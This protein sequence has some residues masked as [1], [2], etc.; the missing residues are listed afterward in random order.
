MNR[1]E[2]II[3]SLLFITTFVGSAF[4]APAIQ[5]I[6]ITNDPLNVRIVGDTS[7]LQTTSVDIEVLAISPGQ[8]ASGGYAN[9]VNVCNFCPDTPKLTA[10]FAFAPT[11]G[12]VEV[13]SVLL[14]LI[15]SALRSE[16]PRDFSIRLNGNSPTLAPI[17]FPYYYASV[18]PLSPQ[19]LRV[20]ANFIDISATGNQV[21]AQVFEVR[22][23][24]EYTF[25][26]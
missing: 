13:K 12:Y 4:A 5:N 9:G 22:L 15:Y 19:D 10:G 21:Q 18:V 23:T 26:A 16:S 6:F 17:L 24:V 8:W 14:T 1:K 7:T 3:V 2:G 20:G 11:K 25:M